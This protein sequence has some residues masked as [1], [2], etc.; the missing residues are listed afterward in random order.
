M[1]HK[2]LS[3]IKEMTQEERLELLRKLQKDIFTVSEEIDG[4]KKMVNSQAEIVAFIR[5]TAPLDKEAV[6]VL[7]LDAKNRVIDYKRESE[8][9]LTQSIVYPREIIKTALQKAA[10]SVVLLH[11]HPS[12]SPTPSEAD[13]KITK[14]LLFACKHMDISLLDHIILGAGEKFYSFYENG[15]VERYNGEYRNL[16]EVMEG[17]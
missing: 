7:Y 4:F 14:K 13:R 3:K 5:A 1:T 10:L 2:A 12:G 17:N 6:Y 15:L 9:T 8:G 16:L 11:N